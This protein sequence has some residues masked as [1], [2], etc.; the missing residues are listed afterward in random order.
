MFLP[1]PRIWSLTV[2]LLEIIVFN[3]SSIL[4]HALW[5]H[6]PR[7][8]SCCENVLEL[9]VFTSFLTYA[10]LV[11]EGTW[12][13]LFRTSLVLIDRRSKIGRTFCMYVQT[14]AVTNKDMIWPFKGVQ[15]VDVLSIISNMMGSSTVRTPL[16]IGCLRS[17]IEHLT[18]TVLWLT[19]CRSWSLLLGNNSPRLLVIPILL[20]TIPRLLR[21]ILR[22]VRGH[23]RVILLI[24]PMVADGCHVTEI[25]AK[26]ALYGVAATT[27]SSSTTTAS[28]SWINLT[29]SL[30]LGEVDIGNVIWYTLGLL[31]E[32]CRGGIIAA[33]FCFW[34]SILDSWTRSTASF[35]SSESGSNLLL[36]NVTRASYSGGKSC[37]TTLS[38]SLGNTGP[39]MQTMSQ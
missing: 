22:L 37:K 28:E 33:R 17:H 1:Y 30:L 12:R 36:M 7:M 23:L 14:P 32:I 11:M 21:A 18:L 29:F 34:S 9:M 19:V 20:K 10:F 4:I 3:L 35:S 25:E 27:A 38:C 8:K 26:L 5:N 31:S 39:Q 16:L 15:I 13:R 6:R 2:N 24:K